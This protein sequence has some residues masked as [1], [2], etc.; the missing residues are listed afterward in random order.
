MKRAITSLLPLAGEGGERLRETDEG[1]LP[2]KGPF[3]HKAARLVVG[4]FDKAHGLNEGADVFHEGH[5]AADHDAVFCRVERRDLQRFE[6]FTVLDQ[7]GDAAHVLS[8]FPCGR[9]EIKQAA[10]GKFP[11]QLIFQCSGNGVG[12][13][14]QFIGFAIIWS[15]VVDDLP[16][17]EVAILVIISSQETK[18]H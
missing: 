3:D 11:H 18:K 17:I 10:L 6:E 7:C 15:M 2:H 9:R 1:P 13:V 16:L 12:R 5:G 4:A 8:L 14:F